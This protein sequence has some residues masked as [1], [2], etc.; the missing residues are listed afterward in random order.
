M[1]ELNIYIKCIVKYIDVG[2][3]SCLCNRRVKYCHKCSIEYIDIVGASCPG[4]GELNIYIYIYI[5]CIV[6]YI[7]VAGASCLCNRRAKYCHKCIAEYI[8][9]VGASCPG[10]GELNIYI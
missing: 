8:A 3:A 6:K 7:D 1:G 9:I 5:W 2:G 4:I 10:I